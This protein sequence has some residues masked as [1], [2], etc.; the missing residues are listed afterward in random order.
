MEPFDDLVDDIGMLK[1]KWND[2]MVDYLGSGAK[3]LDRDQMA[4]L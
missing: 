3:Q 1:W 2:G 4:A